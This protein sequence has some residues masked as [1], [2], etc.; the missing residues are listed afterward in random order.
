MGGIAVRLTIFDLGETTLFVISHAEE[1]FTALAL[2]KGPT[3]GSAVVDAL[4]GSHGAETG[5]GP[6]MSRV[7]LVALIGVAFVDQTV[8]NFGVSNAKV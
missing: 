4:S 3:E 6:E 1:S 5:G 7:A 8:C 2:V